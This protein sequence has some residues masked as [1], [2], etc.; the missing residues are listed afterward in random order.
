MPSRRKPPDNKKGTRLSAG[1]LGR[2]CVLERP[3]RPGEGQH[4]DRVYFSTTIFVAA[5]YPADVDMRAQ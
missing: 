3:V 5:E 1:P 2:S 4:T